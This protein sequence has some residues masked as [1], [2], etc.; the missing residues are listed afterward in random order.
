[1]KLSLIFRLAVN[2]CKAKFAGSA[3]G[4]VWAFAY[5]VVTVCIYYFVYTVALKGTPTDGVPYAL[6]LISG[7]MPWFFFSDSLCSASSV[8]ID[9]K[10]LVRKIKFNTRLLPIIRAASSAIVY[11]PI[12]AISYLVLTLG[13]I[14][15]CLGQFNAILWLFG[16]I[17]FCYGIGRIF[18]VLSA[19]KKDFVY[20][21]QIALQLIFWLTP[22]F[23][24]VSALG[25]TLQKL[26]LLNP[27]AILIEG[28][29]SAILFGNSLSL[30]I[31]AYFWSL[32]ILLNITA[33]II[34][35]NKLAC[36]SDVL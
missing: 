31:T 28:Y 7:I 1:M 32:T 20:V 24:P 14:R 27:Y 36:I 5:P 30:G 29:R 6:W 17:L 10:Y 11:I 25:D 9:Y 22:V 21:T 33:R 18:A 19:Y 13:G 8:F 4:A 26:C 16:G 34:F 2:D 3:L 35:K 23:W 12:L 15:P